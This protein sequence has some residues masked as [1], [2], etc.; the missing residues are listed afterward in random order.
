MGAHRNYLKFAT[1]TGFFAL[2][3]TF[4][5]YRAGAFETANNKVVYSKNMTTNLDSPEVK[6]SEPVIMPSTKSAPVYKPQPKTTTITTQE[7]QQPAQPKKPITPK[8]RIKKVV[9]KK[10][11]DEKKVNDQQN[12]A[13]VMPSSKSGF[14]MNPQPGDNQ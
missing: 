10:V 4:V 5:A 13:P 1:L 12:N 6:V 2:I 9:K 3:G 7:P 11:T 14:I 8:K